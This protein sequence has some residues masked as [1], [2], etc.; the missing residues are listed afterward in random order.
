MLPTGLS[1]YL[2]VGVLL[3]WLFG[4]AV[5]FQAALADKRKES[6]EG[7]GEDAT[8]EEAKQ[9]QLSIPDRHR[10]APSCVIRTL[11]QPQM[12]KI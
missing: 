2:S 8:I 1:E 9:L 5:A 3:C 7:S 11:Q 12:T 4:T 6:Y 10:T